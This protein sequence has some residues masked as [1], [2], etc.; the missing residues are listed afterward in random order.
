MEYDRIRESI[1]SF[2]KIGIWDLQVSEN[3]WLISWDIE[4]RVKEPI[5]NVFS[6]MILTVALKVHDELTNA[7]A[8]QVSLEIRLIKPTGS[9]LTDEIYQLQ[10]KIWLARPAR[11]HALTIPPTDTWQSIFC[12][13]SLAFGRC[14][15]FTLRTSSLEMERVPEL[16]DFQVINALSIH[17]LHFST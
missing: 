6:S 10:W 2:T 7:K 8:F 9:D 15:N 12:S 5:F 4:K 16:I 13:F 11:Y 1:E 14:Q 3:S 17:P